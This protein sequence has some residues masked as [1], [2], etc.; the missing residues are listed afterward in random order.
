M[1]LTVAADYAND[2]GAIRANDRT[3][4]PDRVVWP[5]LLVIDNQERTSPLKAD[6]QPSLGA[7]AEAQRTEGNGISFGSG[8]AIKYRTPLAAI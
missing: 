8:V 6:M 7:R 2:L 3:S 5:Q 4:F 1:I